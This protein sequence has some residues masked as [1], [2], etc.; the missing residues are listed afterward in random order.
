[1]GPPEDRLFHRDAEDYKIKDYVPAAIPIISLTIKWRNYAGIYGER[2]Y[3]I[4][5]SYI[6]QVEK[7]PARDVVKL[8]IEELR[9]AFDRTI[10]EAHYTLDLN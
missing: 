8:N 3:L 4:F 2:K 6:M 1:M 7:L 5:P 10:K 9:A